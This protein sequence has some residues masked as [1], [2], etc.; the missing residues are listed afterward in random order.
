[1]FLPPWSR[2][3]RKFSSRS[4]RCKKSRTPNVQSIAK[5]IQQ[6]HTLANTDLTALASNL[7]L[8][9]PSQVNPRYTTEQELLSRLSGPAFDNAYVRT[10]LTE[11]SAAI[12]VYKGA[13]ASASNPQVRNYASTYLP[14]LQA[15]YQ[16][17]S[18][19]LNQLPKS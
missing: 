15:H 10:Q 12:D 5:I 8:L 14:R 18:Q 9:I 19:L 6:D 4:W 11:H 1:M 16:L 7:G 13:M 2:T 17:L 3:W